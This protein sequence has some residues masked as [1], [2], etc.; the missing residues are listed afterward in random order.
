MYA[1]HISGTI[2]IL[3]CSSVSMLPASNKVHTP[4]NEWHPVY[5]QT[6][7]GTLAYSSTCSRGICLVLLFWDCV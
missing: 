5:I 6:N 7:T 4:D 2:V 3:M 1:M